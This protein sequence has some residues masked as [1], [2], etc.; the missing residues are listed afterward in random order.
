MLQLVYAPA[1]NVDVSVDGLI[2]FMGAGLLLLFVI[3]LILSFFGRSRQRRKSKN[4]DTTML[5]QPDKPS[6]SLD[7]NYRLAWDIDGESVKFI[8]TDIEAEKTIFTSI[9]LKPEGEVSLLWGVENNIWYYDDEQGLRYWTVWD[10]DERWMECTYT[11]GSDSPP[12]PKLLL[13]LYSKLY[14]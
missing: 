14:L 12:P 8:V 5:V 3:A 11:G 6:R 13:Q 7:D 1:R 9:N 10:G 4:Y 2:A